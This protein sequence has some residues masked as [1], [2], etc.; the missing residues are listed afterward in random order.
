MERKSGGLLQAGNPVECGAD[1]A[2][3]VGKTNKLRSGCHG[4]LPPSTAALCNGYDD[5]VGNVCTMWGCFCFL[6]HF[7]RT[8][9]LFPLGCKTRPYTA[10]T[11]SPLCF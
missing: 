6:E 10:F 2:R 8:P 1:R 7:L 9:N 4:E 5:A 11:V 3:A